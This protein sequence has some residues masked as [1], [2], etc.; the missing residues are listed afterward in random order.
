MT[1]V[2]G[3]AWSAEDR[4]DKPY[5]LI[6][7]T[8]W[9]PDN[10]PVYGVKVKVRRADQKKAKWEGY[11]DHR[12]EFALRVPAATADYVVWADPK[13]L[14]LPDG[15]HLGGGQEVKVHIDNDERADVGLHLK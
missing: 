10:R 5:A 11:S 8:V 2:L 7:T 3:K 9:G 6:F 12:G 1:P 14:K 4:H 15:K 13:G